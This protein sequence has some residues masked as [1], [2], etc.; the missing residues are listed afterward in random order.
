VRI[1]IE[2]LKDHLTWVRT[3]KDRAWA[4]TLII[5]DDLTGLN[6]FQ[7]I[8]AA[9]Q[10]TLPLPLVPHHHDFASGF[11]GLCETGAATLVYVTR[12]ARSLVFTVK[13]AK[14]RIAYYRNKGFLQQTLTNPLQSYVARRGAFCWT[15][16]FYRR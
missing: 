1:K 15:G 3:S 10:R 6:G 16:N 9:D 12:A 4:E 8:D 14:Y 11:S 5:D 2:G 7:P 13:I